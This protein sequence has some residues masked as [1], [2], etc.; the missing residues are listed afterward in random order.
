MNDFQFDNLVSAVKSC[1]KQN[2]CAMSYDTLYRKFSPEI[3]D[4]DLSAA[5][6]YLARNGI[7]YNDDD[8]LRLVVR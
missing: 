3:S 1:F 6:N 5:V 4:D 8:I 7:L 2:Y